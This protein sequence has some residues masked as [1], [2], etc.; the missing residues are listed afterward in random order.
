MCC[1]AWGCR[2]L[3]TTE[4]LNWNWH[5]SCPW[6][7]L[8]PSACPGHRPLLSWEP[9]PPPLSATVLSPL[10]QE[11][12]PSQPAARRLLL[13][14]LPLSWV[15]LDFRLWFKANATSIKWGY[16]GNEW[17]ILRA[18]RFPWAVPRQWMGWTRRAPR[19]VIW[20]RIPPDNPLEP[21]KV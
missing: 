3:N 19:C 14:L 10:T 17:G 21:P 20:G 2:E 16:P 7:L 6:R 15:C 1:S 13:P 12:V 5:V 11:A 4:R 9:T 18:A 8:Y